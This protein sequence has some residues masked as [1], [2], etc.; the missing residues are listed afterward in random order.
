MAPLFFAPKKVVARPQAAVLPPD[1]IPNLFFGFPQ[2]EPAEPEAAE[3]EAPRIETPRAEVPRAKTSWPELLRPEPTAAPEPEPE[4]PV[5]APVKLP[6]PKVIRPQA[7]PVDVRP[8]DSNYY[9]WGDAA[10]APKP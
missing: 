6:E 3:P 5:K 4:P 10:E 9:V 7:K 2:P 1:E 8:S